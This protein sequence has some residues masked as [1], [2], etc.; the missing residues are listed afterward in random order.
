[1]TGSR[2]G[3][4]ANLGIP[5]QFRAALALLSALADD[6][7]RALCD[8][9][10]AASAFQSVADLLN[11]IRSALPDAHAA[12]ADDLVPALLS[13]SSLARSADPITI[14]VAASKS[15]NLEL[16]DESRDRLQA[17]LRPLLESKAISSTAAAIDV[18]TQHSRNYRT[19]RVFTDIR[20]VFPEDVADLPTGAVLV[21]TLQL[22]TWD[23]DGNSETIYVAMDEADLQELREVI[24]RALAKTATLRR[25]L[26]NQN[27]SY[28][29]L[30]KRE[31]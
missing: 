2:G 30:D 25:V 22:Q 14:A 24:D 18:L 13:L 19:A 11:H 3:H 27:M 26:A 7:A 8:A 12:D 10:A 17:R 16:D 23:R 5:Q 6:E 29:Q 1:M 21:E 28:F 4:I 9:V 31:S 15:A 20:P